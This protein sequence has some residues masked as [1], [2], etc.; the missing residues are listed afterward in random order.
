VNLA[1]GVQ[2]DRGLQ[3]PAFIVAAN[4]APERHARVNQPQVVGVEVLGIQILIGGG[5]DACD[6]TELV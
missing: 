4:P 6:R 3:V 2:A 1:P 5:P